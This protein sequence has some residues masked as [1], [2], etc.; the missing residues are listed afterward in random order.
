MSTHLSAA[1]AGRP[2]RPVP[3]PAELLATARLALHRIPWDDLI[4][5]GRGTTTSSP[6]V[7][8]SPLSELL[9]PRGAE[10]IR[11]HLEA[12]SGHGVRTALVLVVLGDGQR[13]EPHAE[14]VS[15]IAARI[16]ALLPAPAA[17]DGGG[18]ALESTW[19]LAGGRSAR[20]PTGP[21]TE[22]GELPVPE[23]P[24]PLRDFTE[25]RTA[26]RAVL[27]GHELP[28]EDASPAD[29]AAL[30]TLGA[31][32]VV[33]AGD[34]ASAEDPGLLLEEAASAL[35]RLRAGNAGPQDDAHVTDCE[36]IARVLSALA[37]DRLH[38]ELMAQLVERGQ[39]R[40][41]DRERLLQVLVSD[42]EWRPDPSVCAGGRDFRV[43]SALRVVAASAWDAAPPGARGGPRDAWRGLTALLVLLSWWNHRYASAGALVDD[44]LRREPDSTLAPLLGRMTDTPIPPAWWPAP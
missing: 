17:A 16:G 39:S 44:L 42:P 7:T 5:V 32:L 40:R 12:L 20:L 19:V 24:Q 14:E 1:G 41:I 22:T 25:T 31:S 6:M 4:V 38:W 2:L 13:G 28:S 15:A 30:T 10:Q 8:S 9:A 11:R 26:A 43:L 29:L 33:P 27:D 36:R 3:D 37:V 23:R 34:L 18:L 21:V 35:E